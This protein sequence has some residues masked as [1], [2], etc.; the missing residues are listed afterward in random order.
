MITGLNHITFAVADLDASIAF[1]CQI[2]GF[3]LVHRWPEGAYLDGSGLWLCLSLDAKTNIAVRSD[4]THIAFTV[5]DE[6]LGQLKEQIKAKG[7]PI[8]KQNRSEGDSVYCLDPD[9]HKLELHVGTLQSRL[10]SIA[11]SEPS[12]SFSQVDCDH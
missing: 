9:G 2:L 7:V 6:G 3:R 12:D 11:R 8:W 5:T 10:D 4:Y 1:Y